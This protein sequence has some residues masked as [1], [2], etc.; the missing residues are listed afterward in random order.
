MVVRYEDLGLKPEEKAKEIFKFLGLSY[1][2]YVSMYVKEHTTPYK[3]NKKR[4]D[5]YGT[6]R[7]SKA[8][9]FAWRGALDYQSVADIQEQCEEPLQRLKLRMF[10]SE[11]EYLNTTI[12]VLLPE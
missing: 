4:K 9:I 3:R 10:S 2:K 1:N 12:P 11:D 6:F 8:T 5:A 7:D